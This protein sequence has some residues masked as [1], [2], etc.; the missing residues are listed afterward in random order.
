MSAN[1]ETINGRQFE[2]T[3]KLRNRDV[4]IPFSEDLIHEDVE[5]HCPPCCPNEDVQSNLFERS[6]TPVNPLNSKHGSK[7]GASFHIPFTVGVGEYSYSMSLQG[8][9]GCDAE[10]V[11][12]YDCGAFAAQTVSTHFIRQ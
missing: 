9:S 1:P 10:P 5:V 7:Y 6:H 2:A 12:A 3:R 4:L 8:V 11:V